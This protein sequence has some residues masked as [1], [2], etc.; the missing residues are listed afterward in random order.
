MKTFTKFS[1]RFAVY[2]VVVAYLCADLF[3]FHGPLSK[4]L[5][6]YDP[7]SDEFK[8]GDVVARVF[9]YKISRQQLDR[10]IQERLFLEGK[11]LSDYNQA[12]I[13]L[14]EY[15]ALGELIDHELLRV[16]VKVN[17]KD[18]AVTDEEI[19]ARLE[20]FAKKFST[21]SE[22]ETAL[23]SQGYKNIDE[24][25]YR[26]AA[27]IQQEKYVAMRINPLVVVTEDEITEFYNT[28]RED[29]KIPERVRARH[30]FIATLGT[31]ADE[32][33]QKLQSAL[34]ELQ[35]NS[36]T[37]DE[38]ARTLSSDPATKNQAGDLGW[39]SRDRLPKDFA[40]PVF[41]LEKNKPTLIQTKLGFHIVELTDRLPEE[42]PTLESVREEIKA[43]LATSKRH[44]AVI[45]FRT[46][47]RQFEKKKIDIYQ[48]RLAK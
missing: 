46:A 22:L 34:S 14:L 35:S 11:K 47:L 10:A 9:G 7:N 26:I 21:Q 45:D 18:L 28:H 13:K 43:A 20:L 42:T 6:A 41:L 48:D 44:Q 23:K 37:F 25:R 3:L 32:A 15:A 33:K 39:M 12:Q 4:K 1:I 30:I 2:L 24:L 40:D 19:D 5:N 36:K 17:T 29:L 31:P 38:L 16:K 27:R 8:S